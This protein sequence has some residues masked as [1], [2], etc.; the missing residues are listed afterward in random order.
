MKK[1]FAALFFSLGALGA[2]SACDSNDG[3][4]EEAGEELDEAGEDLEDAADDI[5]DETE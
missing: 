3:P 2:V 1:T 5:E 4:L